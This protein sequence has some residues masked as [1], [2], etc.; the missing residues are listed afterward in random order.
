MVGFVVEN[1]EERMRVAS[2]TSAR[3]VWPQPVPVELTNGLAQ[4]MFD[5]NRES[6]SSRSMR[7]A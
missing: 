7:S 3:P 1:R 6:A 5:H 4:S 2:S